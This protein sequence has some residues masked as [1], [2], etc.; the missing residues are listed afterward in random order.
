MQAETDLNQQV[1]AGVGLQY[2]AADQALGGQRAVSQQ[3]AAQ[4]PGYFQQYQDALR[5]ATQQTGSAYAAAAGIQ[6][7]AAASASTLD[8]Q[9]RA[10]LAGQAQASAQLRGATV[11]PA[12]AAQGQQAAAARQATAAAGVGLT[13]QLGAAE[14]GYRANREV[15]G[16]GQKLQALTAE[17]QRARAIEGQ[18]FALNREK[19]LAAVK[20]KG[21]LQS[22]QRQAELEDKVFGLNVDKAASAAAAQQQAIE[23]RRNARITA[24][25]N[26]DQSRTIAEARAAETARA[27]RAR[28]AAAAAAAAARGGKPDRVAAREARKFRENIN[29]AAADARTLLGTDIQIKDEKGKPT[30]RTRK[31]TETEIRANVRKRYKDRDIANA[32]MDIAI[33]GALSTVNERRLKAR[34]IQI[35]AEWRR[36]KPAVATPSLTGGVGGAVGSPFGT[37][38]TP[39]GMSSTR[40]R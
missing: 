20:L 26:A 19:G 39:G 15:V 31:P 34:G 9:Q 13:A 7:N 6:Q 11:D 36:R 4:I 14:T 21:D 2:G 12:I 1:I 33:N 24:N 16:A 29:T 3:Q 35:P 40:P 23:D 38:F 27:N 18:Q 5:N 17:Q 37:G 8:A 28:E 30:G 10:A 22:A 32:A 25:R